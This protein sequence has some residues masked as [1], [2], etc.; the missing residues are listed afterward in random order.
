MPFSP[1][2]RPTP[3][4]RLERAENAGDIRTKDIS[5]FLFPNAYLSS[6]TQC[7]VLGFHTYDIE[8]GSASNGWR[9]RRFVL[10]Y[11]SWITPGLFVGGSR[12]S[13]R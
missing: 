13:R 9:E 10:N 8:P 6:G 5:T 2:F 3:Q 1:R 12:T 7:C 11:A 4:P